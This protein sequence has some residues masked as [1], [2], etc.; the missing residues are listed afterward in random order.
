MVCHVRCRG[1]PNPAQILV[2]SQWSA[3]RLLLARFKISPQVV[4]SR[5]NA[6]PRRR[7]RRDFPSR[8]PARALGPYQAFLTLTGSPCLTTAPDTQSIHT[9]SFSG[10]VGS[11][12]PRALRFTPLPCCGLAWVGWPSTLWDTVPSCL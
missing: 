5:F 12:K 10:R 6:I 3:I 7:E 11:V 2:A 8:S 9:L 1:E 4:G